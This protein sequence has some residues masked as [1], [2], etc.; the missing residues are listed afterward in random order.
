MANAS[1]ESKGAL[2]YRDTLVWFLLLILSE[3]PMHGY[4]IIKRISELTMNQWRPAAGSIY[5]L[6]S[7]MKDLGLIDIVS[8]EESGVRGGRRIVYSLTE[9]GWDEFRNLL[10][11]KSE[12]YMYMLSNI[13]GNAIKQLKERGF[14]K[15][16]Q[17]VC[18]NISRWL[19][20]IS[21]VITTQC[22]RPVSSPNSTTN[23]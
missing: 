5:P 6:L 4:E 1:E 13:M 17:N 14:E 16:A 20:Q 9:K 23:A 2:K 12:F 22:S 21:N 19:A 15:D 11:K 3:R 18:D 10:A 7:Y 8:V